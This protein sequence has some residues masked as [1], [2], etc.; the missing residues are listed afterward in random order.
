METKSERQGWFGQGERMD[1]GETGARGK[2]EEPREDSWILQR[3]T[4][5]G[6]VT[7]EE[8]QIG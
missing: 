1:S 5:R 4:C 6:L 8:F 2:E 3:K 7:E